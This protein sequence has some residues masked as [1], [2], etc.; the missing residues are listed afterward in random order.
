MKKNK[1][2]KKVDLNEQKSNPKKRKKTV[3]PFIV[4]FILGIGILSYPFISD[5]YYRIDFNNQVNDFSES[6]KDLSQPEIENRMNLARAYNDSLTNSLMGDP[7][8]EEMLKKGQEEYARMLEVKEK[9]GFVEVPSVNIKLPLYA[10]T[11]EFVLEK[12]SG[13]LEGTSLPIGGNS[14]HSVLTAHSGMPQAKLF[15]DL[16]QVK[17]GDKFY[18]HNIQEV[19]AY[20]VDQI[21]VIDPTDFS[22]LLIKPGH[23][24]VT[25]LTCTPVGINSHRLVVRG[26]RIPYNAPVE[27]RAIAEHRAS[28][29]YKYLFYAAAGLVFVL[30]IAILGLYRR[31][32]QYKKRLKALD[33]E[34]E[35]LK[36][37]QVKKKA[38]TEDVQTPLSKVE[39]NREGSTSEKFKEPKDGIE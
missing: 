23:D 4:L 30:L 20:Q 3:W 14:T 35:E 29:L 5:L 39:K 22:E 21:D 28:F 2:H 18:V 19:L 24:Y 1:S 27:E 25:L 9:I 11:S 37:K 26:H 33:A 6:V 16:H 34:K 7:F 36:S 13:H 8:S 32:Q 31:K 10:G 38:T 12:G 17:L 15:T